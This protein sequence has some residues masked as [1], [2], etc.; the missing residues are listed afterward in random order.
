M[1]LYSSKKERAIALRKQGLSYGEI[2]RKIPVA[3]STLSLWLRSVGLSRQITHI[4]TEKKK[5]AQV[6]GGKAR[7]DQRLARVESLFKECQNDI[8]NL[9]EHELLLMGVMLYWA[10]GSKEKEVRP[11]SGIRFANSDPRMIRLFLV[12][13]KRAAH[14]PRET[15]HCSLSIHVNQK[16]KIKEHQRYWSRQTGLSLSKFEKVYYKRIGSK[17]NRLNTGD[18]YHGVL[19]VMVRASSILVRR[20]AGWTEAVSDYD[21]GVV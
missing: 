16:E 8:K 7:H 13:L 14:V 21:W 2:L 17:T 1:V 18:G 9:T 3:K 4:L 19:N 12:W 15:I 5:A 11:G 10:E 6:R 20:I